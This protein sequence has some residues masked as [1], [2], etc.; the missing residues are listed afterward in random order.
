MT[1]EQ[2]E[3]EAMLAE[4]ESVPDPL[5]GRI[6]CRGEPAPEGGPEPS[7]ENR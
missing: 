3:R 2:A 5:T 7:T 1:M 4:D 6:R